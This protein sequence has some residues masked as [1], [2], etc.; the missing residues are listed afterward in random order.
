[1]KEDLKRLESW[2]DQ[3][4]QP[5]GSAEVEIWKELVDGR[6]RMPTQ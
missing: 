2:K 4:E 5:A 1:M 6:E 3:I